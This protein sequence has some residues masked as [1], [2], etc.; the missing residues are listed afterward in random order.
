MLVFHIIFSTLCLYRVGKRPPRLES[1]GFSSSPGNDDWY[2]EIFNKNP[3]SEMVR[4]SSYDRDEY[5]LNTCPTVFARTG[6]FSPC[7]LFFSLFFGRTDESPRP[8]EN[9]GPIV[10]W[11][12]H[13]HESAR[14]NSPFCLRVIVRLRSKSPRIYRRAKNSSCE[15]L[16]TSS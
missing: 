5:F 1:E 2:D 16:I 4:Q 8:G 7:F 9:P 13:S 12:T 11:L 15:L 3:I 10:V 14:S 6:N